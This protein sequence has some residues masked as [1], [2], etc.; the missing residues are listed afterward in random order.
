MPA[1]RSPAALRAVFTLI[2]LL[3]VIAI[4]AILAALLLPALSQAR[5]TAR[6]ID[7]LNNLKQTVTGFY[8]FADNKDDYCPWVY[9]S[10]PSAGTTPPPDEDALPI[11]DYDWPRAMGI[12]N[13]EVAL[14][15]ST[16]EQTLNH[17]SSGLART[18]YTYNGYLGYRYGD[19]S[20]G[21]KLKTLRLS[22]LYLPEKVIVFTLG[23]PYNHYGSFTNGQNNAAYLSY[24][25]AGNWERSFPHRFKRNVAFADGSVD[26]YAGPTNATNG[27]PFPNG[28]WAPLKK[29]VSSGNW[30]DK[31]TYH[32]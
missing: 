23:V 12:D 7:C 32:R 17:Y 15:C 4:I 6:R 18:N 24:L 2:E 3:V 25:H 26:A 19:P 16:V 1:R 28:W 22:R 31:E 11:Q 29:N 13:G 27:G 8:M 21:Y 14:R 30:R 9:K 10:A 5:E 20:N